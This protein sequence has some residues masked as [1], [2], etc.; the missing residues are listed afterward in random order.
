MIA[1]SRSKLALHDISFHGDFAQQ[2]IT[3]ECVIKARGVTTK[4]AMV[5]TYD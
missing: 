3:K 5:N 4:L 2:R 1:S